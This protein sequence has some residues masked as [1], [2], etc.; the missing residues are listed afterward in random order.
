MKRIML[1]LSLGVV[2]V[3]MLLTM[4]S[5]AIAQDSATSYYQ[6]CEPEDGMP[7]D[8]PG[9]EDGMPELPPC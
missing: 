3:V 6:Y 5:P 8:A 1:I 9:G 2:S 4:A 7:D